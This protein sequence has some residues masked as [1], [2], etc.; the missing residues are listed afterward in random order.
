MTRRHQAIDRHPGSLPDIRT[1]PSD[2]T[3]L[4]APHGVPTGQQLVIRCDA[5][6]E[7]WISIQPERKISDR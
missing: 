4:M 5:D 6:G 3:F 2:I 7:V 1:T